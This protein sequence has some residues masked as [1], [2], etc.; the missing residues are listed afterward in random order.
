MVSRRFHAINWLLG[1][2][3]LPPIPR[4]TAEHDMADHTRP[5]CI[6]Q[7]PSFATVCGVWAIRW[8]EQGAVLLLRMRSILRMV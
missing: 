4:G 6:V 7:Y 8:H 2:W 5:L 1:W 3:D